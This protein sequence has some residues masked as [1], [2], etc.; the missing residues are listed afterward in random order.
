MQN[1]VFCTGHIL[2]INLELH[3]VFIAKSDEGNIQNLM[4]L[5]V[6][7]IIK[8]ICKLAKKKCITLKSY[9]IHKFVKKHT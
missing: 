7:N 5:I 3:I 1:S 4:F 2:C 9:K 6:K 8:V